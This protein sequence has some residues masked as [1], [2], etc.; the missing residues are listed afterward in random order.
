MFGLIE[1]AMLAGFGWLIVKGVQRFRGHPR[2]TEGNPWDRV[3]PPSHRPVGPGEPRERSVTM[4]F[5]ARVPE[6]NTSAPA[7]QQPLKLSPEQRLAELKRRYVADEI[8]VEEYE[9]ELDKLIR[10]SGDKKP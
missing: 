2:N 10:P 5:D 9:A 4:A 1:I 6:T 7:V 8:T 3:S